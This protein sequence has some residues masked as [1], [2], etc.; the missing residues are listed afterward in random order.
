MAC[1]PVFLSYLAVTQKKAFLFIDPRSLDE[2]ARRYLDGLSVTVC[3]YDGIYAYVKDLREETLLLEGS[4]VDHRLVRSIHS[5]V[6]V[7]EPH[8]P[9]KGGEEPCRDRKYE[10]GP[11]EGR[12]RDDPLHLLAE[13]ERREGPYER[14]VP[15]KEA[16]PDAHGAGRELRA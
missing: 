3:P 7:I 6:Q 13:K 15:A 11:L 4:M 12:D 14:A 2:T 16:G 5:S 9:G 10:K 8:S 1:D